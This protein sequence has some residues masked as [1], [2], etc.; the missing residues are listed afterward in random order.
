MLT[1]GCTS[2]S[3]TIAPIP[4]SV[5]SVQSN[6]NATFTGIISGGGA[7]TATGSVTGTATSSVTATKTEDK[8]VTATTSKSNT[9]AGTWFGGTAGVET[10]GGGS[11]QNTTKATTTSSAK[12]TAT[13]TGAGTSGASRGGSN[14]LLG[15]SLLIL[16]LAW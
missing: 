16:G 13:G 5:L 3:A 6:Y 12:S 11:P 2:A 10:F 8:S 9:A 15:L 14:T 1:K 7:A 4:S